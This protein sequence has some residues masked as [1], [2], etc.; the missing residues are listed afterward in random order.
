M[1][2]RKENRLDKEDFR[3]HSRTIL[4]PSQLK[5]ALGHSNHKSQMKMALYQELLVLGFHEVIL[6]LIWIDKLGAKAYIT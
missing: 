5:T 3:E 2:E 6:L 4:T 1:L